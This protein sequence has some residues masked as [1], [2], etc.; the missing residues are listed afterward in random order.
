VSYTVEIKRSAE[1]EMDGVPCIRGLRI[2]VAT[3]VEWWQTGRHK[4]R[5]SRRTPTWNTTTS[6][7]LCNLPLKLSVNVNSHWST[8]GEVSG[9]QI[10]L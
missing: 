3:V 10:A 4:K 7:R 6:V 5:F 1:K 9:G 8:A 2:P